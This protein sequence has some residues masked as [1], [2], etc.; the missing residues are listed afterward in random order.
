VLSLLWP[1]R[2]VTTRRPG[3][4]LRGGSGRPERLLFA[5][6]GLHRPRL[7]VPSDVKGAAVMVGRLGKGRTPW[8]RAAQ[9]AAVVAVRS[10]LFGAAMWP[11]FALHRTDGAPDSLEEHLTRRLGREVR[12]G[13][14]LGTPRANQK[15]VLQL[16]DPEGDVAGFAKVGH[17]DL[18]AALVRHEALALEAV[19]RSAPKTFTPPRLL[20]HG[21]WRGLEVCALSPLSGDPGLLIPDELRVRAM[22]ELARLLGTDITAVRASSYVEQLRT[23][24]EEVGTDDLRA[25]LDAATDR[26]LGGHGDAELELGTWHG[27][28]GHWNMALRATGPGEPTVQLWDWERFATGVPVG[29]DGLHFRAQSVR[30][31]AADRDQQERRFLEQVPAELDRF[32]VP[33]ALH[34]VSLLLYLL[35]A[36]VRYAT[37]LNHPSGA[38]VRRRLDW[39]LGLLERRLAGVGSLSSAEGP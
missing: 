3:A 15:P 26:V 34:E 10:P 7:L 16:F 33:A 31:F 24:I 35:E 9:S 18:T 37:D 25:R 19:G 36:S 38:H 5:F 22:V 13:L 21:P 14:M 20:H 8:A 4:L 30:P 11:T 32:G 1:G 12:I 28:W 29:F 6:P 17:N 39:A 27:D 23:R 2:T